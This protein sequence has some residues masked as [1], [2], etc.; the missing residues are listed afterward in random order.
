MNVVRICVA[1]W[2]C[3]V[4]HKHR[5]AGLRRGALLH[6]GP[7]IPSV[8][9]TPA[10]RARAVLDALP[11]HETRIGI[12]NLKADAFA[13]QALLLHPQSSVHE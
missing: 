6:E 5:Y 2:E 8:H 11:A 12:G 1:T 13:K 9:H 4:F 3:Q 10:H 7:P